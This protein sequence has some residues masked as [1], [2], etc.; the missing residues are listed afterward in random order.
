M[1]SKI[2]DFLKSKIS[3]IDFFFVHQYLNTIFFS[4]ISPKGVALLLNGLPGLKHVVYDVMS[5]VLT[6]IDFNTSDLVKP[7]LGLRTVLFHSLELLSSNHLELVSKLCPNVEWLSLDS[8]LFYNLEG[9]NR[10]P[11]LR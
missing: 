4:G 8:A 11:Q 6:Y 10:L 9:L 2:C 3:S 7:L 1:S 5:D